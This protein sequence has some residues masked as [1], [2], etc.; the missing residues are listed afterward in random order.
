MP[1]LPLTQLDESLLAAD[2]DNR[3]FTLTFAQPLPIHDLLL[4]IVRGTNLSIVP[5]PGIE[6]SFI[7]ELKN[8][9]VRQAL[10]L[11]LPPLGLGY[12]V[13]G[14]F[15][16]VFQLEPQTRLY[17]INYIA[18]IRTGDS[19][20]GPAASDDGASYAA[21]TTATSTDVFA[22][23]ERGVQTLLSDRAA[24]NVDRKAGLLQV[25]DYPERLDRV[26]FY[27]DAVMDR[28]FRQVQIDARIIEIELNDTT[29]TALDW[30]V[31][32]V[33]AATM[34]ATR[35]TDRPAQTGLRVT[36]VGRFLAALAEQGTV[37]VLANPQLYAV[38]NEPAIV[39]AVGPAAGT[40][41]PGLLGNPLESLTLSVTPQ[42]APGGVV[43]LSV[44]PLLGLR[45]LSLIHI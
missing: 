34:G 43:M 8:V 14:P 36:D 23:I 18:S 31:L 44:S 21:V 28:A 39:R 35:S 2:L 19:R 33:Q 29:A 17:D 11:I 4:L 24:F 3:I 40:Q 38:N 9:T 30:T 1:T 6:G 42:I 26:G 45:T 22:D 5:D 37:T 20:I 16:R 10:E 27:L 41:A 7:G 25:T 15:I 32:S 12:R 13:E